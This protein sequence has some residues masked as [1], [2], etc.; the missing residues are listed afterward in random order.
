VINFKGIPVE[1]VEID[2]I[3]KPEWW[4]QENP[5]NLFPVL[6]VENDS[7]KYLIQN[8]TT[9]SELIEELPGP[10]LFPLKNGEV[11]RFEMALIKTRY[12]ELENTRILIKTI[13]NQV[14]LNAD[15][16]SEFQKKMKKITSYVAKGKFFANS[17][18]GKDEVTLGDVMVFPWIERIMAFRSLELKCFEN[19]NLYDLELWFQ[20][21][22]QLDFIKKSLIPPQSYLN[23]RKI[24]MSGQY[25]GLVL[26]ASKY[27]EN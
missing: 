24:M 21:T 9:I 11:D 7:Q 27:W 22:R 8:S 2:M 10:R 18:I 19:L 25:K 5:N 3:N 23:L 12:Y 17:I 16:N 26:P 15:F 13:Y 6:K 1:L 14:G 20:R 4:Y